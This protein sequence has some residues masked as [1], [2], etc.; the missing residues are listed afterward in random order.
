MYEQNSVAV[1]VTAYNEANFVGD[2]IRTIPD[3]VD[4]IYAIDDCSTD[5]TWERIQQAAAELNTATENGAT[6][7]N[8]V[9]P[10][11][12]EKNRGVGATIK[13]GYQR[14]L[15]DGIDIVAVMNGD[16]QMNPAILHR[17]IDPIAEGRADYAKGNRLL[18]R[19]HSESMSTWRWFG[20]SVLTFLTKV[21]S[22]YWKTMDPQNGYTAIS[23]HA[24]QQLDL[25]ELYDNYGFCNDILV[26]LNT[27]RM[28][29][30]DVE[31][32]AVYGD[33]ESSITYSQ[34]VPSVSLLLLGGFLG[35]LKDRYLVYD[36]HPL[37]FFYVL[38]AVGFVGTLGRLGATA[39]SNVTPPSSLLVLLVSMLSLFVLSLGMT[40]DL[41]NNER[42]EHTEFDNE[43]EFTGEQATETTTGISTRP[44]S[45]SRMD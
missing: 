23:R 28:R 4:R 17:I 24:L 18:S 32:H 16:G 13:T 39:V 30:A 1:V 40:F 8:A 11:R 15:D 29:V 7:Q 36:F 43:A 34:F 10:I 25:S 31:M 2:V 27:H 33:E 41:A 42:L 44:Q 19:Q 37:V 21:A 22:G 14:A 3:Y 35:R 26:K 12:H 20:N 45:N 5:E 6:S 9:V 38:A